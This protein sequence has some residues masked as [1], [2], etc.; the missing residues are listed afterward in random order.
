[1]EL[2]NN[3]QEAIALIDYVEKDR[4]F[5]AISLIRGAAENS[6]NKDD[7]RILSII[8]GC[9]TMMYKSDEQVFGPLF[10]E[11]GVGR[12]FAPEDLSDADL[13][14][15]RS[16]TKVTES[17]CLRT[18][19]AHI[20]WTITKEAPMGRLAVAGY[21]DRFN[22]TFDPVHWT[23]CYEKIQSAYHI[24]SVMG[25]A[26]DVF[27]QTRSVILQK[28]NELNGSDPSFL[29]L[30]LLELVLKDLGKGELPGCLEIA[31]T[32]FHKNTNAKCENTR[33]ADE[34]FSVLESVYKRMNRDVDI[35]AA[36]SQ[37]AGYYVVLAR[38]LASGKDYVRAV[39]YMKKAC[40][41]YTGVD[42]DI[43][44]ELRLEMEQWQKLALEDMNFTTT[45]IDVKDTVEAVNQMFDGLTLPE[46]I[47][48]FGRVARIYKV[49]EVKQKLLGNRNEYVFS[50]MFKSVLV[51]NQGQT[52]QEL[53]PI[54]DLEENSDAFRK[55]MIHHVAER[56]R[57]LDSIPVGIAFQRLRQYGTISEDT[58]DFLVQDNA[59]VP[60]NRAEIIRNGLCL[61]L[62]GKLYMAMH[63][64]Q[65]QTEHIFRHLVKMCGDTVTF[66]KEDGSEQYKPLS[67]LFKSEKLLECYDE[68]VIFTFQSIMDDPAGENLRN[69]NG[70]GLLE[71]A[72]G[73]GAG[74]MCFVSLL[75]MLLSI[76]GNHTR[77]I[78]MN[79][80]K[81]T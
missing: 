64:L 54:S 50:S 60:E 13:D 80:A 66:L 27:K 23:A 58:L 34:S 43:I 38:K 44:V 42:R 3:V 72:E 75:I 25:K 9:M 46:A 48:Q 2:S 81:R 35:K 17:I 78:R 39:H 22:S 65:P 68:N 7:S 19:F 55:H 28:L 73:N 6:D 24:A 79:L 31:E 29:S 21:L 26:A 52:V 77:D 20:V 51:N 40:S 37:Y 61:A 70:H 71:P 30:R 45:K 18:R 11:Y 4:D 41:I 8:A 69:L 14:I 15:L 5:Q 63:I 49:D 1:M 36:K 33:L 16:V 67:V 56:R 47:V 74:A 59:I 62:N 57:M 12:S 32:L 76:Y 53:P 10:I